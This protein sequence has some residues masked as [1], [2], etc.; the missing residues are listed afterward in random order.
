M[1][2]FGN[3]TPSRPDPH[4]KVRSEAERKSSV[5]RAESE[6]S[7]LYSDRLKLT[8]RK[9]ERDL[10]IRKMKDELRRVQESLKQLETEAKRDEIELRAIEEDVRLAKKR[11][12]TL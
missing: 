3:T 1:G 7:I 6:L 12:V 2:L 5:R 11:L 4:G 9:T 10:A 8:R